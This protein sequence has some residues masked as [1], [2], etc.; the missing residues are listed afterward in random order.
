MAGRALDESDRA[1]AWN[2][3]REDDAF[4]LAMSIGWR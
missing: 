1:L 4:N 3:T 2:L